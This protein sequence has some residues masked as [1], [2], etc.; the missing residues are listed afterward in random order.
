MKLEDDAPLHVA[1][2][3]VRKL[4]LLG[5]SG[6]HF[7]NLLKTLTKLA[8]SV[9]DSWEEEAVQFVGILRIPLLLD[10]LAFGDGVSSGT[11]M[12]FGERMNHADVG[13]GFALAEEESEIGANARPGLDRIRLCDGIGLLV[14]RDDGSFHEFMPSREGRV[15]HSVTANKMVRRSAPLD[16]LTTRANHIFLDANAITQV[17]GI[18]EV[19]SPENEVRFGG[20]GGEE[21]AGLG[22]DD[23]VKASVFLLR[24][25][26]GGEA[27]PIEKVGDFLLKLGMMANEVEIPD[28]AGI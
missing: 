24:R 3:V 14:G 15:R 22:S 20:D 27:M 8:V 17:H 4:F 26:H 23:A 18:D 21:E 19:R 10:V 1:S 7:D 25:L 5:V 2:H 13:T 16:D 11:K 6:E 12:S 9:K 28:L